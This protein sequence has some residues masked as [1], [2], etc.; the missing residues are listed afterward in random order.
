M[1]LLSRSPTVVT[2]CIGVCSTGIGDYVCRG[3]KRYA[4]EVIEWNAYSPEQRDKVLLRIDDFLSK[5][6]S[7]KCDIIDQEKFHQLIEYQG[8]SCRPEQSIWGQLY[9]L[10]TS[11]ARQI[12][13]L[14]DYGIVMKPEWR[15]LDAL[16]LKNSIEDELM[17]LSSAY[18][19]RYI[20]S[21]S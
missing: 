11:G 8:I 21:Y 1:S 4:H 9:Q 19:E 7:R 3:C 6:I 12:K 16:S 13:Q 2:P 5:I 15:H 17:S 10:L 20:I 18:Y 14:N